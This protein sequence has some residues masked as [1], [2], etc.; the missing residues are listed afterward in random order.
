MWIGKVARYQTVKSRMAVYFSLLDSDLG[1]CL[2]D[3]IVASRS[4]IRCS[5]ASTI[6]VNTSQQCSLTERLCW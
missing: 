3:S 5:S 4:L 6:S 1:F 2:F